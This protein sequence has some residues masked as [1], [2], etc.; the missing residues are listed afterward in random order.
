MTTSALSISFVVPVYNRPEELEE[1]LESLSNQSDLDF[2]VVVVE[3]GSTNRADYICEKYREKLDIR[4]FFKENTG[5]G[6]SRNFGV[7]RAKGNYCIFVDSDCILPRDYVAAVRS[8]L[9]KNR[10]DVFGGPDA[11]HA[12]FTNLQKAINYAMTSIFTTGGIRGG[13]NRMEKFHPRSFNMG[14]NRE[15]FNQTEGF[16]NIRFA[17][18]KAAGE[19]LDFSIQIMKK[20]FVVALISEAYLYHK[21][22]ATLRQFMRQ[23]YNFGIARVSVSLRH[24]EALKMVHFAPS[25]FLLGSLTLFLLSITLNFKFLLPIILYA[26]LIFFD[27]ALK[28]KSLVIG[29]LSVITSFV[30]LFAYGL[31]FSEAFIIQRVLKKEM[32]PD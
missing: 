32:F 12:D 3:D 1:L 8:F 25:L 22:R 18:S 6:M 28:N 7:K 14:I 23:V 17:Y 11:A 2:E 4:Y 24:P 5:P 21:R 9:M 27:A 16:P 30:Q 13:K 15:I 19:D 26:T 31:G 20:G 10:V 29:F